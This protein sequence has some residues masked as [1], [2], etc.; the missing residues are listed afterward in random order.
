M[1]GAPLL[2]ETRAN[3]RIVVLTLNRPEALNAMNTELLDMLNDA[4]ARFRD[5]ENAWA[6][7]LTGSG[8]AFCAGADLKEMA[9][10]DKTETP[11]KGL[12]RLANRIPTALNEMLG[13]WKPTIA[14]VNGFA[15]AGGF[16]LAQQCDVRILAETAEVGI[17]EARWNLSA[18]WVHDLT[19]Q[20]GLGHALELALWGDKR[21]TAQRAYEIGWANKVV[22]PERLMDEAMEWAERVVAMGPQAVRNLKEVLYRGFSMPPLE[23]K[24]FAVNLERNLL[25]MEDTREGP[26]SFAERRK[27]AFK[28]R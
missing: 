19:R 21:M 25:G 12:E 23:A 22:P 13:L 4:W 18:G 2:Y 9:E 27:P 17:P 5:D 11:G 1:A 24:G 28:N 14:A 26:R 3:G 6:A 20:I 15:L 7:I 8:R 16:A 10:S